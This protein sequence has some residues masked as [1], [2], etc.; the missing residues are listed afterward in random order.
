MGR[1]FLRRLESGKSKS[2][3]LYAAESL[4][5]IK[6]MR[7]EVRVDRRD[8]NHSDSLALAGEID[9]LN[10]SYEIFGIDCS[11]Q[12]IQIYIHKKGA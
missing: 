1:R 8:T 3:L 4:T 5:S 6:S 12:S 10:E 2:F 11:G 9:R 7:K